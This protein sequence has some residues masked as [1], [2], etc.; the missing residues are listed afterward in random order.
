MLALST[1]I[2]FADNVPSASSAPVFDAN[3]VPKEVKLAPAINTTPA[4]VQPSYIPAASTSKITTKTLKEQK[5]NEALVSLDDAQVELRQE[6]SVATAKY[7][8][9]LNEKE[10]V[11]QTCKNLKREIKSIN[12]KMKNVDKSKKMINKNLETVN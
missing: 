8:E 6:L 5:F 2:V 4:T 9:A 11:A 7:N 10:K 12:D 3:Q 1:Q